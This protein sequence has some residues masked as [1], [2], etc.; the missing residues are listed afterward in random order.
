MPSLTVHKLAGNVS[1]RT[2]PGVGTDVTR[3]LVID[4]ADGHVYECAFSSIG[5]AQVA[6]DLSPNAGITVPLDRARAR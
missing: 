2:E 1:V 6:R 4:T 3:T 5:A